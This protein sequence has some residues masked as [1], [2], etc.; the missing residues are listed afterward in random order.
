VPLG[1]ALHPTQL[2]EAAAEAAI[3]PLLYWFFGRAH[4]SGAVIGLYLALY[5]TARFGLEFFRDHQQP[6]LWGGP[7]TA[8]QWISLALLAAG[9]WLCAR[10]QTAATT[11]KLKPGS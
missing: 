3:F 11:E 10:S 4:R 9:L 2:Y 1:V 6:N 7:L 5:S 8:T